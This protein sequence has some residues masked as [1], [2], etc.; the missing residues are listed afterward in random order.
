MLE[1]HLEAGS[2]VG[3]GC[4]GVSVSKEKMKKHLRGRGGGRE[5]DGRTDR[6]GEMRDP[7]TSTWPP[8]RWM[9]PHS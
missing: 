8:S 2:P 6:G 3:T 9:E 5:T 4:N 7:Y 1:T